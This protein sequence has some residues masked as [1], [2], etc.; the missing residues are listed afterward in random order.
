MKKTWDQMTDAERI[1]DLRKDILTLF[2][3]LNASE[4]ENRRL[5]ERLMRAE[6]ELADKRRQEQFGREAK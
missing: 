6:T 3:A 4:M 1:Q 2:Q 5:S